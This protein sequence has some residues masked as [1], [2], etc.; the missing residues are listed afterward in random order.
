ML[1]ESL[2]TNLG[3]LN[4]VIFLSVHTYYSYQESFLPSRPVR[5]FTNAAPRQIVHKLSIST[6]KQAR[7]YL[8]SYP[9]GPL[10]IESLW[11]K[12]R[13]STGALGSLDDLLVPNENMKEQLSS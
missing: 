2:T 1:R 8:S 7:N 5:P 3:L 9:A 4:N 12:K 13:V 6:F 11:A 10:I